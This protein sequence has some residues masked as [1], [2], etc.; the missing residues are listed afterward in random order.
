V[1]RKL[2]AKLTLGEFKLEDKAPLPTFGAYAERWLRTYAHIHCRETTATNY[3]GLL[4]H[5]VFP[6]IGHKP[7]DAVTREDVK[8]IIAVMVTKG[9]SNST[10]ANTIA[11]VKEMLNHAVD[12]G[13][14]SANPA[15][16]IGRFLRRTKDRRADVN[17]LT[18]E[19]V[20]CLLDAAQQHVPPYYPLFLCAVGTGMRMGELLGLQGPNI[21]VQGTASSVRC[22]PASS[23][24][25]RPA[26]SILHKS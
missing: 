18:R 24:A 11:P 8:D 10:V 6:A 14:L 25:R 4:R 7:L 9:L 21:R 22:A 3:Q 17:P 19:E 2:E 1:R 15:A 20:A 5:H 26:L 12:N 16:R 23:R 13:L